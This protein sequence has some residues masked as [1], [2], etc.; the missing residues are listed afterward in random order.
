M[1][2]ASS[3]TEMP[4][5]SSIQS[6]VLV[7]ISVS[8]PWWG[9]VS[10]SS[11][12]ASAEPSASLSS[13]CAGSSPAQLGLAAGGASSAGSLAGGPACSACGLPSAAGLARRPRPA[14]PRAPRLRAP[15]RRG[16]LGAAPRRRLLGR[17]LLGGRLLGGGS[18]ARPRRRGAG[19][20]PAGISPDS[21]FS[22]TWP[23]ATA[24][25]LSERAE[26]AHEA[27]DGRGDDADEL[28]VEDFARWQARERADLVGVER[29][30][31]HQPA[32]EGQQLGRAGVV[33]DASWRR[34]RRRRARR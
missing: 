9:S 2:S 14:S 7:A 25:P 3:S 33:G 32:L 20:S 4:F 17:R 19:G 28:A 15:R 23:S 11:A 27:A 29:R 24:R 12:A 26:R 22:R 1:R 5:S 30:A 10:A 13:S 18:S 6:C 21:F 34:W 16:L 8:P 31:F